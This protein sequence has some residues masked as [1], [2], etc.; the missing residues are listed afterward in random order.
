MRSARV[1]RAPHPPH[2]KPLGS[3]FAPGSYQSR[4]H[5][6][7]RTISPHPPQAS[8]RRPNASA[9]VVLTNVSPPPRLVCLPRAYPGGAWAGKVKRGEV[10]GG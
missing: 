1:N 5:P 7:K 6:S 4:S 2:G 10:D 9:S 3:P 8:A